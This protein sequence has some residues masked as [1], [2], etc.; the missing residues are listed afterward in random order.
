MDNL[1]VIE[2]SEGDLPVGELSWG[3]IPITGIWRLLAVAVLEDVHDGLIASLKLR[4]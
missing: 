4:T 3:A 2:V 1:V